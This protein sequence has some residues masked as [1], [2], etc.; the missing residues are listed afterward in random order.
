MNHDTTSI[1]PLH[2]EADY[3]SALAEIDHCLDAHAG[4]AE[5]ERLELLTIL[6]DDYEARQHAI[7]PPDPIAAILFALEQRGLTRH[8]LEGLIG[9]SGRVSEVLNRQRRLTLPMIRKLTQSLGIPADSL[10]Q[11]SVGDRN[12]SN[13]ATE[14]DAFS[15]RPLIRAGQ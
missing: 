14:G 12:A 5:R 4:S 11:P 3:E 2:S 1:R 7:G 8:D 9:R 15:H 10:I 13:P 6:V